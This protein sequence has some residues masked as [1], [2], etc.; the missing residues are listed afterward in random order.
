M[1]LLDYVLAQPLFPQRRLPSLFADFRR[2]KESNPDGYD[3]N[4]AAWKKVLIQAVR[5]GGPRYWKGSVTPVDGTGGDKTGYADGGDDVLIIHSGKKLLDR[6]TSLEWGKPLGLS[7]VI[8]EQVATRAFVPVDTFMNQKFSIYKD[9]NWRIIKYGTSMLGWMFRDSFINEYYQSLMAWRGEGQ[10]PNVDFVILENVEDAAKIFISRVKKTRL[11]GI[12]ASSEKFRGVFTLAMLKDLYKNDP[13]GAVDGD[14][15]DSDKMNIRVPSL[16]EFDFKI[17]IRHITRDS[18]QAIVEGNI[19]KFKEG[20]E[21]MTL[22]TEEDKAVAELR[23]MIMI[24][25]ERIT[26]EHMRAITCRRRA[27][28]YMSERP[29]TDHLRSLARN[30]LRK[31][32]LAESTVQKSMSYKLQMETLLENIESAHSNLEITRIM[33]GSLPVL[34]HLNRQI[35]GISKVSD[36]VDRLQKQRAETEEIAAAIGEVSAGE[37]DEDEI[38]YEFDRLLKEETRKADKTVSERPAQ[39]ADD[40]A[41]LLSKASLDEVP[42]LEPTRR[43]ADKETLTEGS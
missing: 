26:S 8:E 3:A 5:E 21:N 41:V 43:T 34:E 9:P 11:T 23:H 42:S 31:A 29:S 36:L 15:M 17:L 7:A 40:L 27:G 32:K 2:L 1:D 4:I 22:I 33:E 28:E 16:S 18:Q 19:I 38:A 14:G 10:L 20:P 30:E 35:G 25:S 37:V 6:L 24:F 12:S 39:N 13:F